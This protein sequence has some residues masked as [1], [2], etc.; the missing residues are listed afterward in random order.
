MFSSFSIC[1]KC[2]YFSFSWVMQVFFYH[3]YS[4]TLIDGWVVG[5]IFPFLLCFF[6]TFHFWLS[7]YPK[8]LGCCVS[9]KVQ[10]LYVTLNCYNA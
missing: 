7:I 5:N 2:N 6:C 9:T 10:S 8:S 1:T 3:Y 4:T